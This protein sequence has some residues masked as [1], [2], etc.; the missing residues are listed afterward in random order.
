VYDGLLAGVGRLQRLAEHSSR[1]VLAVSEAHAR[2]E[3]QVAA[4]KAALRVVAGTQRESTRTL[5]ASHESE[6]KEL[7]DL[8][9]L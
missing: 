1:Q 4:A 5:A 7:V 3:E 8:I 6:T 9:D 2:A